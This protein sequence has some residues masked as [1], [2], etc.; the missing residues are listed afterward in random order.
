MILDEIDTGLDIS[1]V[2]KTSDGK[3]MPKN[4]NR[5]I[6]NGMGYVLNS[7]NINLVHPYQKSDI[8]G[9]L[10]RNPNHI[11]RIDSSDRQGNF[12][13][14]MIFFAGEPLN[15]GDVK[16]A[17]DKEKEANAKNK[18]NWERVAQ[19]C[20]FEISNKIDGKDVKEKYFIIQ[21]YIHMNSEIESED[22][23]DD[24]TDLK[25]SFAII[26]EKR[27]IDVAKITLED[28]K[29]YFQV[30]KSRMRRRN[31]KPVRNIRL[32]KGNISFDSE[33]KIIGDYTK[34]QIEN[35]TIAGEG[36]L[37]AWKKY[38]DERGEKLLKV[39]HEFDKKNYVNTEETVDGYKI[40]FESDVAFPQSY[41][42]IEIY[43]SC[44]ELPLHLKDKKLSWN[45]FL[46]KE[47]E[48]KAASK[49][50]NAPKKST[51]CT[52]QVI[53]VNKNVVSISLKD[54]DKKIKI[55]KKG[56]ITISLLG[57]KMQIER[58]NR[59]WN[60]IATGQS[61]IPHLGLLLEK[62]AHILSGQR[63]AKMPKL[64]ARVKEKI[65]KYEPTERQREAINIALQT[66][67]I[68]LIQGPP[69]TGKTTVITAILE[70][71]NEMQDKRSVCAG[72]V[73]A[74]SYQHDAVDNL[75]G[76][77]KV[78]ASPTPKFGAKRGEN[79][80]TEHIRKWA[81]DIYNR[82]V[83]N[84]P[85][86]N[87]H[88]KNS[89]FF[90]KY[91][92][93]T[94]APSSQNELSLLKSITS[95][96]NVS[97]SI[98]AKA[99]EFLKNI[100]FDNNPKIASNDFLQTVRA[101][102]V[103]KESFSDDGKER[104]MDLY[105][106]I[107]D[108][109]NEYFV[110]R[111][112]S[113]KL[114]RK[115]CMYEFIG[116]EKE[117]DIFLQDLATLRKELMLNFL[118]RPKY[119][120]PQA[121]DE[122][123]ALCNDVIECIEEKDAKHDKVDMIISAWVQNLQTDFGMKSITNALKE[124]SFVYASSSQQSD[125]KMMFKQLQTVQPENIAGF[126][127]T[128]VIDEAARASPPDLLIPV[129]KAAKRI[130]LVGDH[131]Q[132]PQLVDDDICNAVEAKEKER[133]GENFDID[134][135]KE[136]RNAYE[137]SLFEL[138]FE[139]LKDLEKKD[140]IKRTVTLDAQYRTHPV[141]GE[142]ASKCFYEEYGEGYKSPLKAEKF[143]HSLPNLQNKAC[144]W[145]NVPAKEGGENKNG[146]SYEREAEAE[147]I[148]DLL[149][150]WSQSEGGKNLSYG[151]I[152]FYKGQEKLIRDKLAKQRIVINKLKIGTVDSFQGMEFDV[153][154]LSVVRTNKRHDFG[155]LRSPNRQ[156]VSMTR[157]KKLLVVVG[158]KDFCTTEI[159]RKEG[160]ISAIAKFY[161]LCASNEYGD[162][163]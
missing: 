113:K 155:F 92:E 4:P 82:A 2:A 142:F 30:S 15:F 19:E 137:K 40:F 37:E 114:L 11:C 86:I 97:Q 23:N 149:S 112:D 81:E 134:V 3:T 160:N 5:L 31:N 44:A 98:S 121:K 74:T 94:A 101:L 90:I 27:I 99:I 110:T 116:D 106:L 35:I 159:A 145:V 120:K 88:D 132:L 111:D 22:E 48:L 46:I 64:S 96:I 109:F 117:D 158:D 127:D 119:I 148:V 62:D 124:M 157:Q 93:Y 141:L 10:S 50:E 140:G 66:P 161:D 85:N 89:D 29:D 130:I 9:W 103:T 147:R 6:P 107:D 60:L 128:V 150:S 83:E 17:Y 118:P 53:S 26:T 34:S 75:A 61:G 47:K 162:V 135:A 13:A 153:V 21:P 143:D 152:T 55:P 125:S 91:A 100:S 139:R 156:C 163:I 49:K 79:E 108:N 14:T 151:I 80:Y 45:D 51:G 33:K 59:A 123:L 73:L 12:S 18:T 129:C 126:Y 36:Y 122:I 39:A 56:Y 8:D 7:K 69:G 77:T 71:L 65:F 138:L 42:E 63:E 115:A 1:I 133:N 38:T 146:T 131:R 78:N 43:E 105:A 154:F 54:D 144:V 28:G 84:N 58:Q 136:F 41:D 95:N 104:A 32:V 72:R 68:A 52:A 25:A 24:E 70:I 76:K 20:S 102:R 87:L 57:E 67:D 16:I